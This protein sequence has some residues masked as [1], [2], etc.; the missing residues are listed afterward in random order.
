MTFQELG[1][2]DSLMRAINDLGYVNP[3]PIQE[4]TIPLL[5]NKSTNVVALAQTG[6]GKTAAFGL[7]ILN[8]L[9]ANNKDTQALILAPTRELCMQITN[10]LKNFGKYVNG[11]NIVAVYGG[12]S[13]DNQIRDIK[14]GTQIVVATPGRLVDLIER[15]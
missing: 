3:T 1:L 6:T 14:R 5:T 7:P 8:K 9:D 2:Q 12:A 10:D 4:Q 11:L 15:R 13:I